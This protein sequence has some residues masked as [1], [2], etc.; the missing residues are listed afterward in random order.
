[1]YHVVASDLDGTLL[2]PDH[3]LSPFAKETLKLL[4]AQGIHFV[5]ATGRHHLDVAQI[6]DGL[7]ISAFMI[8]SNGA[9]VHN[10]QGELIFS[11]NLDQDIAHDL[12]G[13]VYS[14]PEMLTHVYRGD[15]WFMSRSRPEEERFFQESVFKYKL[16]EPGLLG[17]D[18]VS[19]V[20]FTCDSHEKLLPLEEAIN[21]RWGDRV[22]V[23]FSTLSCLEVMAGGVSKGHALE[24]V[25]KLMGHTLTS[26]IAFGDGMNDFE[27]LSMAGKGYIMRN[28]HQ[29]LKDLLPQLEVIGSNADDAVAH[30]LRRLFLSVV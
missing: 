21:A 29:R 7:G 4:T 14:N 30:A 15:E 13:M 19:K 11:H 28:A 3:T 1:M 24:Q 9:R 8:T 6:R 10:T 12:Y 17:T 25:A 2:S 27:M 16:F 22:N 5:F 18:G 20:F 23:S 26:C